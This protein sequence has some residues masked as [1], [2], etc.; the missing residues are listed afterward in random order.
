MVFSIMID[1]PFGWT[2]FHSQTLL[3]ERLDQFP[4]D[5]ARFS[6]LTRLVMERFVRSRS[7]PK[8]QGLLVIFECW[9][10]YFL[11]SLTALYHTCYDLYNSVE[12]KLSEKSMRSEPAKKEPRTERGNRE[13]RPGGEET[14]I[15]GQ[16]II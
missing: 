11:A 15:K 1:T 7:D 6:E 13:S 5:V 16:S 8:G 2:W 9:H 14:A 10:L 3:G 4:Q 12:N